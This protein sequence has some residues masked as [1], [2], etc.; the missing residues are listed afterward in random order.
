MRLSTTVSASSSR[1]RF[2]GLLENARLDEEFAEGGNLFW[3]GV[4]S[5]AEF[6]PFFRREL[7]VNLI[8]KDL[9]GGGKG[10][11]DH[12]VGKGGLLK[13]GRSGDDLLLEGLHAELD[14]GFVGAE[15][16]H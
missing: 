12:E 4:E 8:G 3:W 16:S 10:V 9:L 13:I 7:E 5:G 11:F 15:A 1:F 14:L 2:S 6:I